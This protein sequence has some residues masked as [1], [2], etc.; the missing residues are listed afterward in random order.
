MRS[1]IIEKIN[2]E[3]SKKINT[4]AQVVY[5]LVETRKVI[6]EHDSNVSRYPILSFFCDWVV[7]VKMDRRGAKQMLGQVQNFYAGLDAYL[8]IKKNTNF[9]PFVMF[10]VLRRELRIFL[11]NNDL[12]LD[13]VNDDKKW[14]KFLFL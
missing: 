8:H 4:E 3:F 6:K 5:I 13:I 11:E 14:E 1:A 12:R 9:F 2:K 7:H 10:I